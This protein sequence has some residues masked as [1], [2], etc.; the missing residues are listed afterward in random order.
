MK[1]EL[2]TEKGGMDGMDRMGWQE[3]ESRTWKGNSGF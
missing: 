2:A 3:R 1:I